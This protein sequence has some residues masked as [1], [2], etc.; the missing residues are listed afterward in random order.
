MVGADYARG[1]FTVGVSVGR[2]WGWAAASCA[3]LRASRPCCCASTSSVTSRRPSRR[4]P[5]S[6]TGSWPRAMDACVFPVPTPTTR[7]TLTASATKP[8]P[9]TWRIVSRSRSRCASKRRDQVLQHRGSGPP[10]CGAGCG[11]PGVPSPPSTRPAPAASG[12]KTVRVPVDHRVEVDRHYCSVPY[13]LARRQL[14]VRRTARTVECF[15]RGRRVASHIRPARRGRHT[16]VAEHTPEKHRRL[17]DW[18]PER[19]V[20]WAER[21][22]R[23]P[24]P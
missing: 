12:W 5:G 2:T 8:Q 20:R 24:P 17:G 9:K 13:A 11:A 19:F 3:S 7:P 14:G 15:H 16:T 21:S 6:R 10:G 22:G 1:P 4:S 23:P 18:T